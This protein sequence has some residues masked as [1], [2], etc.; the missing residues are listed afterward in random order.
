LRL[1]F[2]PLFYKFDAKINRSSY[3][4]SAAKIGRNQIK[5]DAAKKSKFA[6][7]TANLA[8]AVSSNLYLAISPNFT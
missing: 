7:F 4:F 2:L 6:K 5:F 1:K 8:D 3:K